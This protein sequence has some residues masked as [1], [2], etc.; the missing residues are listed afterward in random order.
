MDHICSLILDHFPCHFILDHCYLEG[1][2]LRVP[3]LRQGVVYQLSSL[4]GALIL[5]F[6]PQSYKATE[7]AAWILPFRD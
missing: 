6:V 3:S 2:S 5:T 4:G 1:T 7:S